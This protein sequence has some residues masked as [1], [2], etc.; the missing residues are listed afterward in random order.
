MMESGEEAHALIRWP[1]LISM[2][3]L[4]NFQ[5]IICVKNILHSSLVK[6][7]WFCNDLIDVTNKTYTRNLNILLSIFK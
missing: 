4:Q 6:S 5:Y 1:F 3:F 2:P 7:F